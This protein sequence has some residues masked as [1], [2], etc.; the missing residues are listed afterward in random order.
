MCI[1]DRTGVEPQQDMGLDLSSWDC[2]GIH[3]VAVEHIDGLCHHLHMPQFFCSDIEK[4]VFDLRVFDAEALRHILHSGLQLTIGA[5]QLLLQQSRILWVWPLHLHRVKKFLFVF[6][7]GMHAPF[8]FLFCSRFPWFIQRKDKKR[9]PRKQ[10]CL[11]SFF[12]WLLQI[13]TR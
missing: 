13:D 10:Y 3:I 6:E 2:A 11:R 12:V 8:F 5:P 4:Q 1:R 9:K 7:H